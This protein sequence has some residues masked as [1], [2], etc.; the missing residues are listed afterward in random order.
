MK[1]LLGIPSGGA[2]A[3]PF[4]TS[5][6]ALQ[7]PPCVTAFD[8]V[9]V[10]GNFVPAQRDLIV[11]R[12]I[13]F[14]ADVLVMC[15]DDMVIPPGAVADLLAVLEAD[16]RCAL[17]GALYYSRDGFRPMAVDA[18]D[19]ADTTSACIPAFG[20]APVCVDGVGFGCV[21]IRMDAVKAMEPPYFSSHVFLERETLR[22]RVCDEDYLFCARLRASGNRVILHPGV[23]CGHFDRASGR[24]EPLAWEPLE[25]TSVRRMAVV[26]DGRP[27][28]KAVENVPSQGETHVRADVRYIYPGDLL[29]QTST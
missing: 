17:A 12:A 27:Q 11:E 19:P 28:L 14:G 15:D 9:V 29:R 7:L 13:A 6:H 2:P 25:V 1:V 21:A 16:N 23:R 26:K 4:L 10:Q 5:L 20:A 24:S 18:W 3:E 22:V 8:R